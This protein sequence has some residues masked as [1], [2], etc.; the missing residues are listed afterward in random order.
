M[1]ITATI[2]RIIRLG[3]QNSYQAVAVGT[4]SEQSRLGIELAEQFAGFAADQVGEL[5]GL[6]DEVV[7]EFLQEPG[8]LVV[9][10][11]SHIILDDDVGDVAVAVVAVVV[12][13]VTVASVAVASL[14]VTSLS[15]ASRAVPSM[16]VS[17]A[18]RQVPR[19]TVASTVVSS[20]TVASDSSD[21]CDA[22]VR[23]SITA[24][25][26]CPESEKLVFLLATKISKRTIEKSSHVLS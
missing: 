5:A 13:L 11:G 17:V 1:V 10:A 19:M 4:A 12:P 22:G 18:S 24:T 6:A 3:S 14:S 15:V 2:A 8:L 9:P 16:A 26:Q 20:G 25:I 23:R 21:S 7:A